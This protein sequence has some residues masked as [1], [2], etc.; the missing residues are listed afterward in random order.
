M[1]FTPFQSTLSLLFLQRKLSTAKIQ[2]GSGAGTGSS[3][4]SRRHSSHSGHWLAG[5][6][7]GD[8]YGSILLF[9]QKCFSNKVYIPSCFS[10]FC[11]NFFQIS[12]SFRTWGLVQWVLS[13][14]AF[15]SRVANC[16]FSFRR[17]R[18]VSRKTVLFYK[19]FKLNSSVCNWSTAWYTTI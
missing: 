1:S 19:N 9:R 5:K 16:P 10:L 13:V 2:S 17:V 12:S 7:C 11:R 15:Y 18:K 4:S 14:A 6:P 3:S 8:D